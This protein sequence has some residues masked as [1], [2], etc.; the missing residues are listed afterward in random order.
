MGFETKNS[1]RGKRRKTKI[2]TISLWDL[3]QV[4][5][6]RSWKS[7][8]YLNYFPMGFET[9]FAKYFH[10]RFCLFELFPYGIWNLELSPSIRSLK[11][12]E[13]F[14]YGIWNITLRQKRLANHLF[15]L[16]PY[17]IWNKGFG[18]MDFATNRDLNYFPMGFET[19]LF[20]FL[21]SLSCIW[22]IS[23][24]DLKLT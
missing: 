8:K 24:W 20:L 3:K 2:W 18:M 21:L 5:V 17:G 11:L 4:V 19:F 14:P 15:E 6:S 16:F 7:Q 12:F 23:L 10:I 22:T 13:L 1:T 9:H